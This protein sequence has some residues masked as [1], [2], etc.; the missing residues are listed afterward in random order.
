MDFIT[1]QKELSARLGRDYTD[2]GQAD[3]N[4]RWL[5]LAYKDIASYYDWTWLKTTEM[6]VLATDLTTGTVSVSASSDT[7]TFSSAPTTSQTNRYIQFSTS[8]EWYKITAHTAGVATATISPAYRQ[9]SNLSSGTFTVRTLYYSLS[10]AASHIHNVMLADTKKYIEIVSADKIDR[11][12]PFY[13]DTGS[14]DAIYNWGLDS[15]GCLVFSPYPWPDSKYILYFKTTK[16]ITELSGN[17]DTPLFPDR[18]DSVWV[19]RALMYAYEGSD[20]NRYAIVEK[21]SEKRINELKGRDDPGSG[22]RSVIEAVDEGVG[23]VGHIPY[24][25]VIEE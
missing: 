8:D 21:R 19:D 4:K 25:D 7:I 1:A 6:V 14:P 18:F 3:N 24:P 2:S 5:N 13:D 20:D 12:D 10:S 11:N 16:A 17:T 23:V 9:T 15:S 22:K